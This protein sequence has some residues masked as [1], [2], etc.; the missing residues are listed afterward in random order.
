MAFG[1]ELK[2]FNSYL[3]TRLCHWNE[4]SSKLNEVRFSFQNLDISGFRYLGEVFLEFSKLLRGQ[5]LK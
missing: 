1:V 3:I 4:V 5:N 2:R